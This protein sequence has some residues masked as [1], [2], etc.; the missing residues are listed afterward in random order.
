M[1]NRT[2]KDEKRYHSLAK[3]VFRTEINKVLDTNDFDEVEII[4]SLHY[5]ERELK[6]RVLASMRFAFEAMERF[7]KYEQDEVFAQ[8]VTYC[9]KPLA[10][11]DYIH[12]MHST[13][14]AFAIW[15]LDILREEDKV[16]D[17]YDLLPKEFAYSGAFACMVGYSESLVMKLAYVCENKDK[18]TKEIFEKIISLLPTEELER[19]EKYFEDILWKLMDIYTPV[20]MENLSK[21]DELM[22]EIEQVRKKTLSLGFNLMGDL[23][24]DKGEV[25][26]LL[27]RMD[28]Y[29]EIEDSN[30][31]RTADF[32]AVKPEVIQKRFKQFARKEMFDFH[33]EDP[34]SICAMY[35][36]HQFRKD[37][38]FWIMGPTLSLLEMAALRLPWNGPVGCCEEGKEQNEAAGDLYRLQ[39]GS[40]DFE[41]CTDANRLMN[42]AQIIYHLTQGVVVPRKIKKFDAVRLILESQGVSKEQ[43]NRIINYVNAY[44]SFADCK[45]DDFVELDVEEL[46][47]L[48]D[49]NTIDKKDVQETVE[50]SETPGEQGPDYLAELERIKL[51]NKR[52]RGEVHHF[53]KL[54]RKEHDKFKAQNEQYKR[55]H[56]EL[57]D[58][59]NIIFK[60]ATGEELSETDSKL[61]IEYPYTAKKNICVFG[62]HDSWRKAIKP[63]FT[64]VRFI[65]KDT[66][67]NVDLIKNSDIIWIQPN[68]LAHAYYY[69]IIDIVRT[70]NIP[71]RY[72][73]YA[74]ATKCAEQLVLEDLD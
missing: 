64:N 61:A 44:S 7:D 50:V 73:S 67:P 24:V 35:H 2:Q 23:Q 55:E 39:Y 14:I 41:L 3:Q 16:E 60:Q 54:A 19:A 40:E 52:L 9:A 12:Q 13:D 11:Y 57:V 26:R 30:G 66:I 68:S 59:R 63:M 49:E 20:A 58:L 69:S 56:A 25:E 71:V 45:D 31:M 51:E 4:A 42:E 8:A 72:F 70:H 22:A 10:A 62:G 29:Y 17:L 28:A 27:A 65:H 47:E 74:S 1:G 6:K 38:R 18:E 34:Y 48:D 15:A 5:T 53:E 33:V 43:I 32:G 36:I 37:D 46:L 21:M